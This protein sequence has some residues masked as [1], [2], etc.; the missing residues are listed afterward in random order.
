MLKKRASRP[1]CSLSEG[2]FV[3]VW[4]TMRYCRHKA[5]L[6]LRGKFSFS[7]GGGAGTY[8]AFARR[9]EFGAGRRQEF[10]SFV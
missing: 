9:R 6:S 4:R 2:S 10:L 5:I 7:F 1:F 8:K 3:E